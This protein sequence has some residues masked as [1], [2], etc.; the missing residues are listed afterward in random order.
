[1][2]MENYVLLIGLLE[3]NPIF[4]EN[5]VKFTIKTLRRN[6]REDN[7]IIV[8]Y[9]EKV[10]EKA[11]DFKPNDFILVKGILSTREVIKSFNCPFCRESIQNQGTTT[12][13]V[14]VDSFII[15]GNDYVLEDFKEVSNNVTLL[16]SLCKEPNVRLLQKTNTVSTQYQM[17]INRKLN[18][19][20]EQSTD[21]PWI[22]SFGSQ[23]EKDAKVLKLSSQV[24]VNGGIQ[25]RIVN[26]KNACPK[27]GKGFSV[28]DYVTEIVPY[29]VEYL[30]NC[31]VAA[32]SK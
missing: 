12:E 21:Y 15:K 13:V 10:F 27:C 28:E 19:A 32:L 25:T 4:Y 18:L 6:G 8:N 30:N 23:A 9:N 29:S 3:N 11:K 5:K 20:S 31:N 2:A 22:N 7:P 24:F 17:A 1:M 14:A 16:G 26:K